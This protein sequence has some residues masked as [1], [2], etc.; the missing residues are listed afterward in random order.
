M[1]ILII[2]GIIAFIAFSVWIAK[3]NGVT[4]EYKS[5]EIKISTNPDEPIDFGYKMVW[6]AVKTDKKERRGQMDR[7][8]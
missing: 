7:F 4:A 1:K 6:I 5:K 2:L 3:R 8:E